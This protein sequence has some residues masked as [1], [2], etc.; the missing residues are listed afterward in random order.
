MLVVGEL[1]NASRKAVKTAI[2][3]QDAPCVAELARSQAEAGAHYIDVNAGVFLDRE[4]QYLAWLVQVVQEAVDLPCAL[5]SPNPKAMEAAMEVH[6]GTP[7]INS[8]SLEKDRWETLL[9][10]AAHNQCKVVA[11]CT[12]DEGM[13]KTR[14]QRVAIAEKMIDGLLAQGVKAEN[15]YVDPLVQ[16]IATDVSF[17]TQFLLAMEDILSRFPGVHTMCGL[18]NISFGLPARQMLNR[19]F[20]ALAIGRGLDGAII[21]PLDREMMAV[22]AASEALVGKDCFCMNYIRAYRAG[23]LENQTD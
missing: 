2:M 23:A 20:M 18:S 11:L 10:L 1:L 12:S 19:T 21:N 7:M 4:P 8:I 14:E 6:Q 17:G 15:I 22:I 16:P 13:P 5:D 9:P 3:N